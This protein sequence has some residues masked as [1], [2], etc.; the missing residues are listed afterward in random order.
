MVSTTEGFTDKSTISSDPS[1]TVKNSSARK[2]LHQF[3]EYLNVKH[4][5]AV[6]RLDVGNKKRKAVRT[7]NALCPNTT[8][9]RGHKR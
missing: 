1:V 4:R 9:N 2:S 5:N 3:S 8:K 7:C 6:C